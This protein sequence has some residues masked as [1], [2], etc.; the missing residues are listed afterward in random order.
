MILQPMADSFTVEF[1]EKLVA[2]RAPAELQERL[3]LLAEKANE[4]TLSSAEQSDYKALVYTS[5]FVGIMQAK[6]RRYLAERAA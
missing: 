5:T 2:L 3:D 1:A 6:A 4:G